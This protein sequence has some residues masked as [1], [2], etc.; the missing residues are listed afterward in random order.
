[1]ACRLYGIF[2]IPQQ[3]L[4]PERGGYFFCIQPRCNQ[5]QLRIVCPVG[6]FVQMLRR[7]DHVL[8]AVD[9]HGVVFADIQNAFDSQHR[10]A[11]HVQKGG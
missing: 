6:P 7:I 11:M 4:P 1:M 2:L 8:Y 5:H 10:F 9:Q 3:H